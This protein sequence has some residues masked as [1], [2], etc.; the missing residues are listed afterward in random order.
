MVCFTGF[1]TRTRETSPQTMTP[2]MKAF[3][4]DEEAFE[5]DEEAFDNEEEASD[6]DAAA[7]AIFKSFTFP[8][9][10][11]K[12]KS[13]ILRHQKINRAAKRL[14]CAELNVY[15]N[16]CVTVYVWCMCMCMCMCVCVSVCV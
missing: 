10:L 16:V 6:N 11:P 15:E 8:D 3:E 4:I 13:N 12:F 2:A 14:Q 1:I 9:K 7:S 5:N